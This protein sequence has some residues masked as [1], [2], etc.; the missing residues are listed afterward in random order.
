MELCALGGGACAGGQGGFL[1][2]CSCR[3]GKE[4]MPLGPMWVNETRADRPQPS[5]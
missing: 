3:G 2:D 5:P 1:A 4:A